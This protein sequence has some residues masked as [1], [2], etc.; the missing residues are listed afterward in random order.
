MPGLRRAGAWVRDT[1][2]DGALLPRE[3]LRGR[4]SASGASY[5]RT[6]GTVEAG[7]S[8]RPEGSERS[9]TGSRPPSTPE[10]PTSAASASGGSSRSMK[11]DDD[12][13]R[14]LRGA[15]RDAS[16]R[17]RS[18]PGS[19]SGAP[20]WVGNA[21]LLGIGAAVGL[22]ASSVER[23][24]GT[25]RLSTSTYLRA[26]LLLA[27]CAL[28]VASTRRALGRRP[29]R[30]HPVHR[31]LLRRTA[32]APARVEDRLRDVPAGGAGGAEPGCTPAAPSPPSSRRS[33]SWRSRRARAP[34]LVDRVLVDRSASSRS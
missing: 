33:S 9:S 19:G 30:Q 16:T 4:T 12:A 34:R 6:G 18:A 29:H 20:V 1:P 23:W 27:A 8:A 11:R 3:A 26:G 28:A 5:R 2:C 13:G 15:G 25:D 10:T 22:V 24:R 32:A 7:G 21:I 14:A 17:R 31:L